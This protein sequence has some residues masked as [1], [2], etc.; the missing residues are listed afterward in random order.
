MQ[1]LASLWQKMTAYL[2]AR[3]GR[4][5][6]KVASR[7]LP[8]S[9]KP[10]LPSGEKAAVASPPSAPVVVRQDQEHACPFYNELK[11]RFRDIGKLAAIEETMGRDSLT[12]MP[13]GGWQSRL[14]QLSYL[15]RHSHEALMAPE[16]ARL[17]EKAK[18]HRENNADD[19]DSWD[20][21]NL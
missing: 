21:A 14:E 18:D 19:W 2:A 16:V 6:K 11:I 13:E 5:W 9:K 8:V 10:T 17:I 1:F 12:A 3:T 4:L 7:F 15:R 20:C